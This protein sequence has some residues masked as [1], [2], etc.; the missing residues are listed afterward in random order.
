MSMC[1]SVFARVCACASEYVCMG[2]VCLCV[3][4]FVYS[5]FNVCVCVC[6]CVCNFRFLY[7]GLY[8]M[9]REFF[10]TT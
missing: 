4:V 7:R 3:V 9:Y 6:V 10:L 2:C 5:C 8:V 1:V